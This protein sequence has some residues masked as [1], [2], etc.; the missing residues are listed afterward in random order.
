VVQPDLIV[1]DAPAQ[2]TARAI[3]GPPLLVVEVLSSSTV[4]AD[5]GIKSRRYAQLGVRHHWIVDVEAQAIEC[6]RL[7]D[8]RYEL[9]H[10]AGGRFQNSER[11]G[12]QER[13]GKPHRA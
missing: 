4:R 2:V 13:Q 5:R 3:E 12:V 11:Q 6:Y 7:N 8:G 1:I 9:V 10:R